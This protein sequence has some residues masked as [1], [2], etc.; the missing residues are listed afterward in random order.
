[1]ETE[2]TVSNLKQCEGTAEEN[3][4]SSDFLATQQNLIT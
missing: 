3:S 2:D 4:S 1:M